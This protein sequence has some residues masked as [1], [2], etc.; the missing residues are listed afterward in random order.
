M[1]APLPN[2]FSMLSRAASTAF[3]FSLFSIAIGYYSFCLL[4]RLTGRKRRLMVSPG[5]RPAAGQSGADADPPVATPL[6]RIVKP[7][8]QAAAPFSKRRRAYDAVV[9]E[10]YSL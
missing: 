8:P 2:C 3:V 5:S 1:I 9:A 10:L 7:H 4:S 6:G